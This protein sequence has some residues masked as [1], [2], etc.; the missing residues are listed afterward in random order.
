MTE[1]KMI[2]LDSNIYNEERM[3]AL[4]RTF[5]PVIRFIIL[6]S[7]DKIILTGK[8]M[9]DQILNSLNFQSSACFYSSANSFSMQWQ[10]SNRIIM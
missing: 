3:S 5:I 2:T 8:F 7:L 10:F 1:Y 4:F 9:L 6:F